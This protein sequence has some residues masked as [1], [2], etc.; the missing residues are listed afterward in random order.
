MR[1]LM[2]QLDKM[3]SWCTFKKKRI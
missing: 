2:N 1:V 3:Y